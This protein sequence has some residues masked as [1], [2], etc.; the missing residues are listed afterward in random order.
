[1]PFLSS[2]PLDFRIFK[3]TLPNGT[4][5]TREVIITDPG[6]IET[7][8]VIRASYGGFTEAG[9]M[10]NVTKEHKKLQDR[11]QKL[12]KRLRKQEKQLQLMKE[13][14]EEGGEGAGI[15]LKSTQHA[16]EG[17]TRPKKRRKKN[18]IKDLNEVLRYKVVSM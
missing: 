9:G 4:Q 7:L 16:G 11:S 6:K 1:M 17:P 14:G 10:I 3:R 2:L 5:E 15:G 13:V 12:K 8:R 18:P